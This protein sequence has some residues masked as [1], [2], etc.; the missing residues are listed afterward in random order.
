MSVIKRSRDIINSN[1][2]AALDR[3]EEPAKMVRMMIR[4]ME[5]ALNRMRTSCAVRVSE[6][7][8]IEQELE[9]GRDSVRKWAER[10]VLAV[11]E[12]RDD[13]AKD[14]LLEKRKTESRI[15]FMELDHEHL[16]TII[17]ET[18]GKIRELE[19]KLEEAGQKQFL[20][21]QRGVH[22]KETLLVNRS[23]RQAGSCRTIYR[24]DEMEK[25]IERMEAEAE[26]SGNKT[27]S[28]SEKAFQD[29]EMD[30]SVDEEL[31][32]MKKSSNADASTR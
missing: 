15:N 9:Q 1:I 20:L 23:I 18:R 7:V 29:L 28:A 4:E 21:I 19:T 31:E 13:L 8:R 16:E 12:G 6:K 3:V 2:N 17:A 24:F 22:A 25:K 11:K 5:D 30:R 27:F 32:A 14:A 26:L 10:S